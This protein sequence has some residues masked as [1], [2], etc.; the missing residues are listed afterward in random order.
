VPWAMIFPNA[1]L[2][3]GVQVPRHPSQL[4]EAVL[5]GLV[6]QLVLIVVRFR[7]RR[8]GAVA[9][10]FMAGYAI[11]R[12][13]GEQFREP[14]EQIGFWFGGITQGQLLSGAMLLVTMFLAWH[15]FVWRP[16][17]ETEIKSVGNRLRG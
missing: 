8:E 10:S 14:D 16:P 5:E 6:L 13:V 11:L 1:P 2:V 9:L 7:S 3:N 4:Y 17:S 15:Q 12:I